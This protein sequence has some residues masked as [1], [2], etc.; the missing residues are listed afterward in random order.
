MFTATPL[1]SYVFLYWIVF[2]SA[3]ANTV[4][5]NPATITVNG[6]VSYS[7]QAVFQP[8]NVN[9]PPVI[10]PIINATNEAIVVVLAGVGG[11]TTPTPGIYA[12]VND[13]VFNITA[14]PNSGWKF[15]HW[16]ISGGPLTGHGGYS[17]TDTPTDNPYNVNHGYGYTYDYQPVFS[18]TS[19]TS[20]TPTVSE[21]STS[22]AIIIAVILV[23]VAFGT[24]AYTKRIKK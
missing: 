20:P 14:I 11:T 12:F 10:T 4:T 18:P 13:T 1:D 8:L 3:G 16:V 2:T 24:Y 23:I 7:I 6:G 21:F 17:F 9:L 19:S 15:D 5:D 22:T